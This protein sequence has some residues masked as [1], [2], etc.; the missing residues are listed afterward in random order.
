MYDNHATKS[1]MLFVL[2]RSYLFAECCC[3]IQLYWGR[4][5]VLFVY[6]AYQD[7]IS[8][9]I[10]PYPTPCC[11]KVGSFGLVGTDDKS[12]EPDC[13]FLRME[14]F[15]LKW[16]QRFINLSFERSAMFAGIF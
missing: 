3:I 10:L 1:Q 12:E 11:P 15:G 6:Q 4:N 7:R 13:N 9:Y 5:L 8:F 16:P 14:M 2:L